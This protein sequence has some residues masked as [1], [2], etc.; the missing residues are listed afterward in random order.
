MEA[1]VHPHAASYRAF[2]R[3]WSKGSAVKANTTAKVAAF[4]LATQ[5]G[6]QGAAPGDREEQQQEA[7]G[8]AQVRQWKQHVAVE[9]A[10]GGFK[11]ELARLTVVEKTLSASSESNLSCCSLSSRFCMRS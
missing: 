6:V 5:Q 4:I 2:R 10:R 9:A 7:Q 1:M 11:S 8:L 3:G